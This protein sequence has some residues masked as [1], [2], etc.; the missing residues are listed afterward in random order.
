[1]WVPIY[2]SHRGEFTCLCAARAHKVQR[3]AVGRVPRRMFPQLRYTNEN[4]REHVGRYVVWTQSERFTN[5]IEIKTVKFSLT[6]HRESA[7]AWWVRHP[8]CVRELPA[9]LEQYHPSITNIN[10]PETTFIST[11]IT[12]SVFLLCSL[13]PSRGYHFSNIVWLLN[14]PYTFWNRHPL[15]TWIRIEFYCTQVVIYRLW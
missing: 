4:V 8:F 7:G 10:F 1:M 6:L 9:S 12:T 14:N 15:R 13:S 11:T 2:G 3:I 5:Y